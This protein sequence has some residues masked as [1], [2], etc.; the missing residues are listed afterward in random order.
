MRRSIQVLAIAVLVLLVVALAAV[1]ARTPDEPSS[2][3]GAERS[4]LVDLEAIPV[5]PDPMVTELRS[6]PWEHVAVAP[7]GRTLDVYFLM[8]DL[9]CHGLHSIV[10][11][12]TDRGIE[13]EI[14][15]GTPPA[16]DFSDPFEIVAWA[17]D[18]LAGETST[19]CLDMARLYRS[20]VVLHDPLIGGSV[21]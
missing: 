7:D 11:E 2:P 13:L 15:T 4:A 6:Q 17:G 12:P 19:V 21:E 1:V 3:P 18:L 9:A 5:S 14:L 10:V 16:I 20:R 8:G